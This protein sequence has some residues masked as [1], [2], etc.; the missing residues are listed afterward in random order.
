MAP[1]PEQ[2][3]VIDLSALLE[4][5]PGKYKVARH[6]RSALMEYGF[7]YIKNHGVHP[8]LEQ[9][10]EE[11]GTNFFA[12]PMEDKMKISLKL[13]G[14]ALRGYYPVGNELTGGK[15]DMKEG[16]YFGGELPDDHPHVIAG[17]H[18]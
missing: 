18:V 11:V 17:N 10:L 7:F 16:V 2:I 6:I 1:A 13:G 3:P 5:T 14:K 9:R 15:P 12:L 4:N 8:E